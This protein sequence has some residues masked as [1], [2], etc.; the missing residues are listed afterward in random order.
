LTQ[1]E[2]KSFVFATPR[3]EESVLRPVAV[4]TDKLENIMYSRR[5]KDREIV[6]IIPYRVYHVG[7][8]KNKY[9]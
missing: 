2:K 4:S 8:D 1:K 6:F 7:S 3:A 5:Q 9:P